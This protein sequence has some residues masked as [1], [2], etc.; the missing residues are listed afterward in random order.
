MWIA[1]RHAVAVNAG[2]A[3]FLYRLDHAFSAHVIVR[4][5]TDPPRSAGKPGGRASREPAG[6]DVVTGSRTPGRRLAG[7][8]ARTADCG[9]LRKQPSVLWWL[10]EIGQSCTDMSS[11]TAPKWTS[12]GRHP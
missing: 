2:V 6:L 10:A 7:R 4:G 12:D 3:V 11:P 1:P 8:A 9:E 5:P